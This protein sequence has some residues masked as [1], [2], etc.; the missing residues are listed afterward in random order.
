M[1]TVRQTIAYFFRGLT[2]S[3]VAV[4]LPIAACTVFANSALSAPTVYGPSEYLCFDSA[5]TTATGDCAGKDSPFNDLPF[6]YFHFEDFTDGLLN[7]PGVDA[8]AAAFVISELD[9]PGAVDSVD[10]DDGAIDGFGLIGQSLFTFNGPAGIEF[11]FDDTVLGRF[12]THVGIVWTDGGI[13]APISFEVFDEFGNS[14]VGC[15]LG[16]DH[17]DGS[18][19]G[20]TAEDRFYGCSH[21]SGI[22]KIKISADSPGFGIEVDHLQYGASGGILVE[23]QTADYGQINAFTSEDAIITISNTGGANLTVDDVAVTAGGASFAV[24]DIDPAGSPPFTLSPGDDVFVT[25]TFFPT[26]EGVHNG[27]LTVDSDDPDAPSIDVSLVGNGL[28]GAIGD[29]ASELEAAVE[30]A[31]ATG[32]LG[33]SGPGIS[34]NG[35]LDAFANMVETAGDL[36]DAGFIEDACGQLS[37]ALRRVD[38]VS[39]LPDFVMGE[40]ATLLA[41]QIRFL[42]DSLECDS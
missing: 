42:R 27:T 25:V 1:L 32:D 12:P 23:P 19:F 24:T 31:I 3:C 38:G 10:E 41:D 22:S 29:Q 7:A 26:S 11:T 37:S 8:S 4:V 17:A 14:I 5:T 13:A 2:A 30:D 16:G 36:V 15:S 39:P 28:A 33:G 18:F 20:E 21:S 35:R 6:S 34:A 9:F 40:A